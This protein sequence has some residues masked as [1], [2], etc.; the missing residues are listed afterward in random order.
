MNVDAASNFLVGSILF[1]LGFVVLAITVVTINNIVAK[2]W[3][4]VRVFTTDSWTLFGHERPY[5][6]T[7]EEYRKIS[8]SLEENKPTDKK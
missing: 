4:P 3:K 7:E 6:V 2:Y 1:G 8:P 5:F